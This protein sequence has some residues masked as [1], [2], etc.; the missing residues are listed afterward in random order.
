[1]FKQQT[2]S[3]WNISNMFLIYWEGVLSTYFIFVNWINNW[4]QSNIKNWHQE[5]MKLNKILK[6]ESTPFYFLQLFHYLRTS[7][8]HKWFLYCHFPVQ[9]TSLIYLLLLFF[10]APRSST[11]DRGYFSTL[12]SSFTWSI[13]ITSFLRTVV[14]QICFLDINR[15]QFRSLSNFDSFFVCCDCCDSWRFGEG[16]LT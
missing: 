12:F 5:M 16:P 9:E 6:M 15:T 1:M 10:L 8:L 13:L 11:F 4:I 7:F 3:V 14:V 2:Y